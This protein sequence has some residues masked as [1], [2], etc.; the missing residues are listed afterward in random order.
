M[1]GAAPDPSRPN[2]RGEDT[3]STPGQLWTVADSDNV[4]DRTVAA[5]RMSSEPCVTWWPHSGRVCGPEG[6]TGTPGVGTGA[7]RFGA[8]QRGH[9]RISLGAPRGSPRLK[10]TAVSSVPPIPPSQGSLPSSSGAS[11][12]VPLELVLWPCLS[13]QLVLGEEP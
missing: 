7:L 6:G 9:V 11:P 12:S 5:L 13:F 10:D 4:C 3:T 8:A 1:W 2:T